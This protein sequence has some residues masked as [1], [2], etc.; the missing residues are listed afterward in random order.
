MTVICFI[1]DNVWFLLT[2]QDNIYIVI[3]SFN[4]L[5]NIVF[6]WWFFFSF[7]LN[8]LLL[9]LLMFSHFLLLLI[10]NKGLDVVIPSLLW[11]SRRN[12]INSGS[13]LD[14]WALVW[15]SSRL[16]NWALGLVWDNSRLNNWAISLVWESSCLDVVTLCIIYKITWKRKFSSNNVSLLNI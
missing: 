4:W 14:I 6:K 11:F 1:D 13:N 8:L 2:F 16:N 12:Y 3:I 5:G 9:H 7:N 15:D 10:W